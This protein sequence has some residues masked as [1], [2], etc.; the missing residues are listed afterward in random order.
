MHETPEDLDRLQ[1]LLDESWEQAGDHLKHLF[2]RDLLVPAEELA[3]LLTGV[4][5]LVLATV[6]ANGEPRAAPVDGLFYRGRWHFGSS[7]HSARFRHLRKRP[8][9]SASH[10]RGEE[11][12]VIVHGHA[13]EIDAQEEDGGGFHRYLLDVYGKGWYSF[14]VGASYAVIEPDRMFSRLWQG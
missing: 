12:A 11:L 2:K 1:T 5:V 10:V 7:P 14:G 8:A 6:T 9:V 13:R 3:Q 4:Q